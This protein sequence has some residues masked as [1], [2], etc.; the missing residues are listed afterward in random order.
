MNVPIARTSSPHSAAPLT[1]DPG[2]RALAGRVGRSPA[3]DDVL[4]VDHEQVAAA[5]PEEHRRALRATGRRLGARP[6]D[7][8]GLAAPEVDP[9]H[10]LGR[11]IEHERGAVG[12]LDEGLQVD[13]RAVREREQGRRGDVGH[14]VQA[15]ERGHDLGLEG[16]DR[17]GG[18]AAAAR[19]LDR[20]VRLGQE[21][22][23]VRRVVGHEIDAGADDA[24]QVGA[25][26]LEG[27][28]GRVE[29][30][31]RR[32]GRLAACR[33]GTPPRRGHRPPRRG[34]AARS[35][36]VA[37]SRGACSWALRAGSG[38]RGS[39]ARPGRVSAGG[40]G[41]RRRRRGPVARPTGRPRSRR[42]PNRRAGS[43]S[44]RACPR[45]ARPAGP[46]RAPRRSG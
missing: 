44:G 26:L 17:R 25:R 12:S 18:D 13:L 40:T 28:L 31:D 34:R 8:G 2:D 15:V 23:G 41:R 10:G 39:G 32:A 42:R 29:G 33:A 35:P 11:R 3:P 22:L 21:L 14:L 45:V 16:V 38:R 27:P 1:R 7:R 4:V 36:P 30:L 20:G 24:T 43:A 9:V 6:E 5:D 37:A 46:A 19:R